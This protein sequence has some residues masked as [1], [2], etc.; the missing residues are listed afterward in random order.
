[1]RKTTSS[2]EMQED[3]LLKNLER[4]NSSREEEDDEGEVAQKHHNW[5]SIVL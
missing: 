3:D 4:M 1:M 5:E 2:I